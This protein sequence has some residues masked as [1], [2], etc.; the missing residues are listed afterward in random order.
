V[1]PDRSIMIRADFVADE[2]WQIEARRTPAWVEKTT[3]KSG[4]L[5]LNEGW[6]GSEE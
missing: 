2:V 5:L 4:H 3:L 1:Q 6:L